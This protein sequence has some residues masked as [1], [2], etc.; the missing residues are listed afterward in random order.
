MAT[1]AIL[2]QEDFGLKIASSNVFQHCA[3]K[4]LKHLGGDI[5]SCQKTACQT[6][7]MG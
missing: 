7:I 4:F 2:L 1:T 3:C 5:E 6:Q